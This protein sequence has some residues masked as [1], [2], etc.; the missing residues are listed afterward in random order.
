LALAAVILLVPVCALAEVLVRWT[1][2]QVPSRESLGIG[3]LVVPAGNATAITEAIDKGYRVFVAVEGTKLASFAPVPRG[4]AGIVVEGSAPA[5]GLRQAEARFQAAGIRLRRTDDRGKW[6]HIRTNWV[7]T[8]RG[9][10]QVTGR[11]AQPW[12]ENNAALLRIGR[13]ASPQSPPL[14]TYAWKPI[15]LSDVDEGPALENYL[16]AIAETGSF[17]GDL[18]LPLHPRLQKRLL[19]GQPRAREEWAGIRRA[20]EFYAW[21]L[22]RRYEPVANIGVIAAEPMAGFE[23]FNLL[24]RHNLPFEL[25]S[26]AEARTRDLSSMDLLISLEAPGAAQAQALSAFAEKGGAVVVL[27]GQGGKSDAANWPW[28]QSSRT[29]S[30]GRLAYAH[31]K[32]QVIELTT[33]V[34]DP[35]AFAMAMRQVL[36]PDRRVIDIWNGITVLTGA[37]RDPEGSVLVTLLN[38]AHQELPVQLRVRGAFSVVQYESPGE[39]PAL[40]RFEHRNGFTELV[41]PALRTGGRLFLTRQ[42]GSR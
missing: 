30:T 22:P 26:P 31:G 2:P 11:S 17:G 27:P 33:P 38:Y 39:P 29:E 12:I 5:G 14:L 7:T 13:A 20:M 4:I 15:V 3:T 19:L 10:L 40:L 34:A 16:V 8:E 25:V 32:G 9:V 37:Y 36:G 41:V 28:R 42:T 23:L 21:D 35:D 6:P 18:L 24:A 1:E